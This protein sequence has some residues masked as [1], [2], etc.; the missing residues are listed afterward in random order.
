MAATAARDSKK[1]D[2]LF[3]VDLG[4]QIAKCSLRTGLDD[5][6]SPFFGDGSAA[7]ILSVRSFLERGLAGGSHELCNRMGNGLSLGGSTV[8][9]GTEFTGKY[10]ASSIAAAF[11][12]KGVAEIW[13]KDDGKQWYQ[14]MMFFSAKNERSRTDEQVDAQT[15]RFLRFITRDCEEKAEHFRRMGIEGAKKHLF[16]HGSVVAACAWLQPERLAG[17]GEAE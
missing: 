14:A 15:K 1:A 12:V 2:R 5:Y 9:R 7:E 10:D 6:G 11:G 17:V 3:A 16:W 8:Q 4:Q 13:H